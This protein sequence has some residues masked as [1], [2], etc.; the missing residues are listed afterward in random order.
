MNMAGNRRDEE[1]NGR[2]T[3]WA[4]QRVGE[5]FMTRPVVRNRD[6]TA[7]DICGGNGHIGPLDH[8]AAV[9]DDARGYGRGQSLIAVE[10]GSGSTSR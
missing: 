7:G 3:R 2:R 6:V 1:G 9:L 10:A 4:E 8:V 5:S